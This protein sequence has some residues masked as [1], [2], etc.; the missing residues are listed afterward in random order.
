MR[1]VRRRI[2]KI[3]D[4]HRVV[5]LP[6]D[7]L[8]SR[9]TELKRVRVRENDQQLTPHITELARRYGV[10]AHAAHHPSKTGMR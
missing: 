5:C 4:R 9:S 6:F 1:A 7:H 10:N 2:L 8:S 3:G